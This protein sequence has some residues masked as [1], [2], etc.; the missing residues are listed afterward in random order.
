MTVIA[1]GT[2]Q[3]DNETVI[4]MFSL[5]GFYKKPF[6]FSLTRLSQSRQT[7]LKN[8]SYWIGITPDV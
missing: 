8:L 7:K 5:N 1:V 4:F 2:I 6:I 3:L